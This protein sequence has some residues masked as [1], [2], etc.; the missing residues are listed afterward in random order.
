MESTELS[1]N[2]AGFGPR[3]RWQ[4]SGFVFSTDFDFRPL[5]WQNS[6][7]GFGQLS[8]AK[9]VTALHTSTFNFRLVPKFICWMMNYG[10]TRKT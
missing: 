1:K 7:R 6:G 3:L 8:G 2:K 10:K 4:L 9:T 5:G